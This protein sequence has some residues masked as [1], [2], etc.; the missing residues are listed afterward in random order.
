MSGEAAMRDLD[1][2]RSRAEIAAIQAKRKPHAVR[3]AMRA[4]YFR[5]KLDHIDPDRVDDPQVWQKIPILDKDML[6]AMSDREFYQE[7]CVAPGEGDCVSQYWRSGG[8]TG[9][10]LFYPRTRH[11]LRFAL[12]GF[13][14]IFAC[15]G[16]DLS[17]GVH[18]SFPLGIHPV[19]QMLA[20]AAERVG[21]RVLLAGAGTTTPSLLQLELMS[22]L[23]PRLWMG[24]SSYG[25]HLANLADQHEIDLAA[26]SVEMVITSAETLSGAKRSKLERVWG[27]KVRDSFGMTEAGMMAAEDGEADGFRIFTDLFHVEVVDP[28]T[29]LPVPRGEVGALVVTPLF[30]NNATPFLRWLSGDLVSL[31]DDVPGSGPFAVFPVVKHAQRL[32][33]FLKIRGVNLD[34]GEF[35]DLIFRN[36]AVNDFKCEAVT[37]ADLELLRV[38]VELK[39]DADVSL[40]LSAVKSDIK[41][42]FEITAEVVPL[43]R[44]TLAKEFEASVKAPR[45][46]DRRS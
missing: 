31:R 27:A 3:Q 19:G 17:G 37:V 5:G 24:M 25:L 8:S 2:P 34:H 20:R 14:R 10:P 6:R 35:E 43:E 11:D 32:S 15:A 46:V 30:T 18:C 42:V 45:I 4:P 7:F 28:S 41:R 1:L 22:R 39:R 13:S 29:H 38:F 12:T 16:A 26:G 33:G 23:R 21:M 9:R 36:P 40:T 44:G